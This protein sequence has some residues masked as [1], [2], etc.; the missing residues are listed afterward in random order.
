[1]KAATWIRIFVTVA[2]LAAT[3]QAG[4][5]SPGQTKDASGCSYV[6]DTKP[7]R[8]ACGQGLGGCYECYYNDGGLLTDC[9]ENSDG[10]IRYCSPGGGSSGPYTI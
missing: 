8:G 1:M 3:A 9:W 2:L 7:T 6:P 10:T 4:R 5:T